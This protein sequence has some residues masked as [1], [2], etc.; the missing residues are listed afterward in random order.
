MTMKIRTAIAFLLLASG[1]GGAHDAPSGWSYP[2]SCCSNDDC[3]EI[4]DVRVLEGP[5]GFTV[6][7]GEVVPYL[8]PRVMDSPD[9]KF[10]WC[11]VAGENTGRTICLFAPPRGA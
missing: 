8:D 5:N 3:R 2:Y 1:T 7:S 9:G 10:H 4:E 11:T 6:P